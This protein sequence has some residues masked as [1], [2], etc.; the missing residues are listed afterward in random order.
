MFMGGV[1]I[2]LIR[3]CSDLGSISPLR[4]P[5]L[6]LVPQY[7]AAMLPRPPSI[8]PMC[9][10]QSLSQ[11]PCV[12]EIP[13]TLFVARRLGHVSDLAKR[14]V[15]PTWWTRSILFICCVSITKDIVDA[16]NTSG[17]R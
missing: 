9:P 4:R 3:C 16:Q 8:I 17:Y 2:Q 7:P 14:M 1:E 6:I 15:D 13:E 12:V 5:V 11:G 10:L